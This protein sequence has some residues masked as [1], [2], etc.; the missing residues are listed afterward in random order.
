MN[1]GENNSKIT[2]LVSNLNSKKKKCLFLIHL[3]AIV[4]SNSSILPHL[5]SRNKNVNHRIKKLSNRKPI[6]LW[7]FLCHIANSYLFVKLEAVSISWSGWVIALL[8]NWLLLYT[9]KTKME[10]LIKTIYCKWSVSQERLRSF[11]QI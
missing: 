6:I 9:I 3:P 10:C 1:R 2:L 8:S 7:P 5:S 11:K 4:Y